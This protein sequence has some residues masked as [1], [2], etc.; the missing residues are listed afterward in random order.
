M[1]LGFELKSFAGWILIGLALQGCGRPLRID[2]GGA[3]SSLSATAVG[4][5]KPNTYA[6]NLKWSPLVYE[7]NEKKS[8]FLMRDSGEGREDSSSL[9]RLNTNQ[10]EFQDAQPEAGKTYF[11]SIGVM[12]RGQF[13]EASRVKVRVPKDLVISKL[14]RTSSLLD[15]AR[16]YFVPGGVIRTEGDKFELKA[17][18]IYSDGGVIESF[19]SE[20]ERVLGRLDNFEPADLEKR[21]VPELIV[22]R[23][24]R[25]LGK[26]KIM[27]QGKPG[28]SLPSKTPRSSRQFGNPGHNSPRVYCEIEQ[29]KKLK[30]PGSFSEIQLVTTP[31]KNSLS[32]ESGSFSLALERH[33]G[34]GGRVFK[35]P[36]GLEG[37]L[38]PVCLKLGD[39]HEGECE[40][41]SSDSSL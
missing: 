19:N 4:L 28:S 17:Q 39:L 36:P 14:I 29:V 41:F 16:V 18:E 20:E 6:V 13:I 23:A 30:Q 2:D 26:L 24:Q 11:Y 25:A 9:L 21:K 8:W 10:T 34:K 7:R 40:L 15:Y 12:E 33:P 22:I 35:E 38:S 3:S 27:A 37:K 1:K 31:L 5:N 32:I